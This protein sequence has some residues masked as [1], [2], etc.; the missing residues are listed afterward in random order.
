MPLF[1]C[2]TC[3]CFDNTATSGYWTQEMEH[4]EKHGTRA[5]FNP[6]CSE[7]N[8]AIGKWHGEWKQ[9]RPVGWKTDRRGFIWRPEELPHVPAHLGPF[10]DVVLPA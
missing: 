1:V 4:F 8:P 10:T 5:G 2:S 6:Q 7:H 9:E 3:H